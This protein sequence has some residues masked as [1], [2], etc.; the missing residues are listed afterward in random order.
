MLEQDQYTLLLL[1]YTD[2]LEIVNPLGA[3]RGKYKI[4]CVY[5]SVLNLHPKYRSELQYIH[6]ILLARNLHVQKYGMDELLKPMIEDLNEI[7][8]SGIFVNLGNMLRRVKVKGFCFCGDNLSLNRIGGFTCC[9]S[10]GRV[11]RFCLASSGNLS[12]L[13][14]E[15]DCVVR[16]LDAHKRHLSCIEVNPAMGKKIYGVTGPSPLLKVPGFDVTTQLPP[17]IMHDILEGSFEHVLRQV[18]S[19]LINQGILTY[20]DLGKISTFTYGFHDKKTRP[21]P[22][23]KSFINGNSNLKGTASQKWCPMRLLPLILGDCVPLENP[24]WEVLLLY[25]EVASL[26]FAPEISL[27]FVAYLRVRIQELLCL[28]VARYP[29]ASLKPKLRYL[30]HYPR[31]IVQLGPL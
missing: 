15:E 29:G 14:T 31:F 2:E 30:V 13:T 20:D 3:A 19:A 12:R 11:C 21:E 9:F 27:D 16:C 24:D 26:C 8:K 18:L 10:A 22:L 25:C 7:E 4:V 6:L 28:F 17:D 23:S 1:L 5:F